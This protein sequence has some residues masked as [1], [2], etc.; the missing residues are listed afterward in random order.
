[1]DKIQSR[2]LLNRAHYVQGGPVQDIYHGGG[3]SPEQTAVIF[4]ELHG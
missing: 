4:P 3:V 1:M 2:I